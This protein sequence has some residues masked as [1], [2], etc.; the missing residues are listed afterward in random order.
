MVKLRTMRCSVLF[1]LSVIFMSGCQTLPHKSFENVRVGMDKTTVLEVAGSPKVSKRWHG[2]D[3]WVYRFYSP[4][5]GHQIREV[6]FQN[7]IATYVGGRM[8]ALVTA[9]DQDRL[10]EASNVEEDIR[11]QA[12]ERQRN[13][14][15]GIHYPQ[16]QNY[17]PDELDLKLYDSIYHTDHLQQRQKHK[18]KPMPTFEAIE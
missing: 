2:K 7:G 5:D 16:G 6:H 17:Q 3:R 18:V 4:T 1:A 11:L 13:A 14:Q 15:L 8:N 12:E 10:N 9:E